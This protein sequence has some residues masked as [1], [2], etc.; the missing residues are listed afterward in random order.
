MTSTWHPRCPACG[1]NITLEGQPCPHVQFIYSYD[2]ACF[3]LLM[4]DLEA[5]ISQAYEQQDSHA[6]S[7]WKSLA[8][9]AHYRL[10]DRPQAAVLDLQNRAQSWAGWLVG[11]DWNAESYSKKSPSLEQEKSRLTY[12]LES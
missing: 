10:L 2:Q 3:L 4:P 7:E 12:D 11:F 9:L 6:Y 1:E 8:E 5:V